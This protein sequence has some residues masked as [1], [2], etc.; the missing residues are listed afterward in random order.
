MYQFHYFKILVISAIL[1]YGFNNALG[2]QILS[3]DQTEITRTLGPETIE[4]SASFFVYN[5]GDDLIIIDRAESN[6]FACK[7][8]LKDKVIYPQSRAQIDVRFDADKKEGIYHNKIKI[9]ITQETESISTLNFIVEIPEYI[10][11]QPK[12]HSWDAT[13]P[14]TVVKSAIK[15]DPRFIKKIDAIEYDQQQYDVLLLASELDPYY[16]ELH[17]KPLNNKRPF[18]SNITIKASSLN[19]AEIIERLYLFNSQSIDKNL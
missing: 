17:I 6:S 18:S 10:E 11:C 4:A 9:Y 19:G 1:T 15:I 7:T 14:D 3:W 5:S 16:Y 2:S 13:R 8:I 12:M